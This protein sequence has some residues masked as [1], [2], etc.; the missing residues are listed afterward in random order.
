M[1]GPGVAALY[2]VTTFALL[3][4]AWMAAG[5]FLLGWPVVPDASR[6]QGTLMLGWYALA[7]YFARAVGGHGARGATLAEA[8]RGGL[9]DV[10]KAMASLFL[11]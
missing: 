10:G 8:W 3:A 4:A 7:G 2:G 1:S 5:H 9:S 6:A 11:R